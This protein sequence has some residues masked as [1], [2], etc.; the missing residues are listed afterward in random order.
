[1]E[2]SKGFNGLKAEGEER[3]FWVWDSHALVRGES[4][5]KGLG[6]THKEM[7]RWASQIGLD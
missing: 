1:M 5:W 3:R 6:L 4:I 2:D 7:G